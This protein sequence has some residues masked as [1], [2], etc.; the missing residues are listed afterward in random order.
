[1]TIPEEVTMP[2]ENRKT[3]TFGARQNGVVFLAYF[4]ALLLALL[5][6]YSVVFLLPTVFN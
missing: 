4:T 6:G 3:L 1:M 2:L 5:G